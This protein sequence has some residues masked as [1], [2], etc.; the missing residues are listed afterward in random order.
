MNL[1]IN[2][3]QLPNIPA[4]TFTCTRDETINAVGVW[5]GE[6]AKNAL[7]IC[8]IAL[9]SDGTARACFKLS[10]Y[11]GNSFNWDGGTNFDTYD[12]ARMYVEARVLLGET[13]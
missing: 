2:S 7:L 4:D 1:D 11:D 8:Y 6:Y 13:E 5:R 10:E 9:E 12:E 3:C